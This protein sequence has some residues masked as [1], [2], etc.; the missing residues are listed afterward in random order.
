MANR[1]RYA[2]DVIGGA[3][4]SAMSRRMSATTFAHLKHA[5]ARGCFRAVIANG[6]FTSTP[7]IP[8]AQMAV[9][10]RRRGER[11]RSTY[12]GHLTR[13][14]RQSRNLQEPGSG[15]GGFQFVF[16]PPEFDRRRVPIGRREQALGTICR[17]A[18]KGLPM[19]NRP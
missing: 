14:A 17:I 19:Q 2:V 13:A 10:L 16:A 4:S 3:R 7:V 8:K 12:C 6:S 11:V 1:T 5:F 18:S 15:G 9:I